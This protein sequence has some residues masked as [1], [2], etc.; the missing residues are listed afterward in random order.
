MLFIKGT[1]MNEHLKFKVLQLCS[2]HYLSANIPNNWY[3]LTEN[4]QNK[5]LEDNIW[6]PFE[7]Y[8]V[9]YVWSCIISA[10]DATQHFIEDLQGD[11]E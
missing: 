4:Q 11:I 5:F 1:T 3:D 10:A 9:E 2:G 7:Y 8:D 6:E